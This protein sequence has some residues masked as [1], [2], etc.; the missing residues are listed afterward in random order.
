MSYA[1]LDISDGTEAS[2]AYLKLMEGKLPQV[3]AGRLRQAL[4]TYC[5]Q[6]TRGMV[7][8]LARLQEL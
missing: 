4:R 5:G 1:D 3:E 6:D 2:I 8:L 7:E